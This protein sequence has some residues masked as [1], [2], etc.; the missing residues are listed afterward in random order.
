[1]DQKGQSPV[2]VNPFDF[3]STATGHRDVHI[4]S[5]RPGSAPHLPRSPSELGQ[6]MG[7]CL[8]LLRSQELGL[9]HHLREWHAQAVSAKGD[10]VTDVRDL[11]TGVLLEGQLADGKLPVHAQFRNL[12]GDRSGEP[13]HGRPLEPGGDGTIQIL[14]PHHVELRD[15]IQV[16]ELRHL[17]GN[18]YSLS[19]D[20]ERRSVVH[21]IRAD[22]ATLEEVYNLLV[23]LELHESCA[24]VLTQLAQGGPHMPKNL[25]IHLRHPSPRRAAAE[26][27]RSGVEL[28]VDLQAG[29]EPEDTVVPRDHLA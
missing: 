21:L 5:G 7:S 11:P 23:S 18:P 4:L 27:L 13:H 24:V 26:E 6:N 15:Q 10:A 14:L 2:V 20:L 25:R 16:A 1:M 3:H 17:D 12:K 8:E 19:I 29:H 9:R 22:R 28:L